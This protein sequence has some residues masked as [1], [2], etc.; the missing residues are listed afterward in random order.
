M[1]KRI[2]KAVDKMLGKETYHVTVDY[3]VKAG[4]AEEA[5]KLARHNGPQVTY[6]KGSCGKVVE[7]S[8][9]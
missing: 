3:I 1:D 6:V 5:I 8:Y 2:T 7:F 4:S 9:E